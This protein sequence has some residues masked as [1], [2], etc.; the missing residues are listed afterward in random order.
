MF[1][2]INEQH[3]MY[4]SMFVCSLVPRCISSFL[5]SKRLASD[6]IAGWEQG[7]F[8]CMFLRCSLYSL[9]SLKRQEY[10]IGLTHGLLLT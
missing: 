6:I 9:S 8:V 2:C 1:A 4:V 3:S 10:V 5:Y 7:R